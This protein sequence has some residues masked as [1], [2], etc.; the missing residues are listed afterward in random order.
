[1]GNKGYNKNHPDAVVTSRKLAKTVVTTGD[2]VAAAIRLSEFNIVINQFQT[3]LKW[4]SEF[5]TDMELG[6]AL[7][8]QGK[9]PPQLFRP[10]NLK[11]ALQQIASE[12]PTGWQLSMITDKEIDLRLPTVMTALED[13]YHLKLF[14]KLPIVERSSFF[15]LYKIY[16]MPESSPE[17]DIAIQ[18]IGLP[19]F[20][21][22]SSN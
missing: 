18:V 6:L 21:A 5:T 12:L 16:S 22:I 4:L 19:D 1:M 20:I 14:I 17:N 9:L 10:S 7:L 13:E 11:E 8:S 2:Q 3:H 15:T